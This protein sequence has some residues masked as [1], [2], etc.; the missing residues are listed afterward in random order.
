MN[1]QPPSL[2][3]LYFAVLERDTPEARHLTWATYAGVIP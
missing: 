2:D 1:D 3:E